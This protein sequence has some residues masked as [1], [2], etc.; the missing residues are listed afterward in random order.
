MFKGLKVCSGNADFKMAKHIFLP[1]LWAEMLHYLFGPILTNLGNKWPI[2]NSA[3]KWHSRNFLLS[4]F[5]ICYLR[6]NKKNA[7]NFKTL[8]LLVAILPYAQCFEI[9]FVKDIQIVWYSAFVI[10]WCYCLSSWILRCNKILYLVPISTTGGVNFILVNFAEK[11]YLC[12]KI[13]MGRCPS[14]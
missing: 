9:I 8:A 3:V 13:L 2:W 6:D 4:N 11:L 1:L 10:C 5:F 12:K 14:G 7:K